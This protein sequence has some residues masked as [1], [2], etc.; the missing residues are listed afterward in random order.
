MTEAEVRGI[1][2]SGIQDGVMVCQNCD[3]AFV[4]CDAA[5]LCPGCRE[6]EARS[7]IF[8]AVIA[9][10]AEDYPGTVD[11]E[12]RP[13]DDDDVFDLLDANDHVIATISEREM[14]HAWNLVEG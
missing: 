1:T 4:S 8:E 10:L 12:V 13:G 3:E 6:E 7:A 11:Y 14:T 9:F 5:P 2:I